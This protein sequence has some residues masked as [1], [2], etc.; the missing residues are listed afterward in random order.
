MASVRRDSITAGNRIRLSGL[1]NGF[2]D[3]FDAKAFTHGDGMTLLN[4]AT[5]L[6][7][8]PDPR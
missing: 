6:S 5:D 4:V 1:E 8:A 7:T 2:P 3:G